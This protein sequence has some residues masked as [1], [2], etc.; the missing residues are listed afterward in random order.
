M[1]TS[2]IENVLQHA[3]RPKAPAGLKEQ[4]V[5]QIPPGT[6]MQSGSLTV[7]HRG[8]ETWL[9]RWWPALVPTA[10][11]LACAGVI[12]VQQSEI[13]HLQDAIQPPGQV[14]QPSETAKASPAVDATAAASPAEQEEIARLKDLVSKLSADVAR[15]EQMQAENQ[16]LRAQLTATPAAAFTPEEMKAMEEAK[17]RA[18]SIQCINNLKQL[19]LA[20]KVWALDNQD[21]T[22]AQLLE[23][24]NEMATPKILVCPAD[25]GHQAAADWSS[26]SAGNCSYEYLSPS[27][28]DG[29]EPN[30][31]TFRCPIH[32]H[33]GLSDG[34]VQGSM[35]KTHPER[36]VQKDGKLFYVQS[37][38]P[39]ATGETQPP[40][41]T[42]APQ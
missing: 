22:P 6:S 35:A 30:R 17:Q 3:P 9:A 4:L 34:S 41:N 18:Q 14:I 15:L 42:A 31:I 23:M 27:T 36:I 28:R 21:M 26:F 13:R 37:E 39:P 25:T 29:A 11:S 1:N 32:G 40:A 33:I 38:A 7:T 5:T 8:G 2:E 20:V 10:V 12:A 24:T 19:G 16:K